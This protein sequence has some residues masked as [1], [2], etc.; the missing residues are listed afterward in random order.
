MINKARAWESQILR[1]TFRPRRMPDETKVDLQNQNISVHEDLL[2]ED[3]SAKIDA[4][5]LLTKFWTTMTWAAHDGDVPAYVGSAF[6][7]GVENDC[8]VEKS[9]LMCA[10]R[11][12]PNNVQ[13]WKHKVGFHNR[14]V[15]LD[16]PMARWA[17]EGEGLDRTDD[18]NTI[19]EG[20]CHSEL[21]RVDE[22]ARGKKKEPKG[23]VP[24]KKPRVPLL[25][26]PPL[27]LTLEQWYPE[28]N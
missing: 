18:A 26:P 12:T 15:Q 13:R 7:I 2:A 6:T 23:L 9:I 24:T 8:M 16:T 14:G 22:T 25:P 19:P 17:G 1:L 11:G 5:K 27:P 4:L 21:A 3:G 10:W 20:G 28:R